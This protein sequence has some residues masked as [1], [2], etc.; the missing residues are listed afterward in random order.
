M[1]IS[2]IEKEIKKKDYIFKEINSLLYTWWWRLRCSSS[3]SNKCPGL[4]PYLQYYFAV[5]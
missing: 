4:S 1:L 2:Y 3:S 5:Q